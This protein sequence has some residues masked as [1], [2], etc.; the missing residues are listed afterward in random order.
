MTDLLKKNHEPPLR[1]EVSFSELFDVLWQGKIIIIIITLIFSICAVIYSLSLQNI[2]QSRAL[3]SPVVAES[4]ISRAVSSYSGLANIAGISLPNQSTDS[5]TI[6]ALD[7]LKSLSFFSENILPN[8][9]L[10]DLMALKTWDPQTN[11]IS[12]NKDIYNSQDQTWVRDFSFPQSQIPSAQESFLEFN[13]NHLNV[14]QNLKTGFVSISVKHQSPYIAQAWTE[15]IVEEINS[16]YRKKDKLETEAA[17][18]FLNYQIS[19]TSYSE[20]K[21]VIAEL[22]QQKTQKLTLIEANDYY[23]FDYIDKPA[24]MEKKYSPTRSIICIIGALL[25]GLLG[26]IIVLTKHYLWKR[27]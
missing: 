7:K 15:L 17:I 18:K 10:P 25:G 3:L 23:V 22:L 9:F 4:N 11:S 12:Y 20:I 6:K 21:Q 16:F 13:N 19:Q 14:N 1:N 27:D 5:N 8:I 24:A 26:A 2:Y